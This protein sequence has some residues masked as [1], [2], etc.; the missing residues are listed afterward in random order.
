MA[1][2]KGSASP[3]THPLLP[4]RWPAIVLLGL[5]VYGTIGFWLIERWSF[6]DSLFATVVTISPVAFPAAPLTVG[7]K[8]FTL[9]LILGGAGTVIYALG[10]FAEILTEDRL[11]DYRRQHALQVRIG[12]LRNHSIVCGYGRMGHQLALEFDEAGTPYIV[13]DSN[14]DAVD[15]LR[16]E[17]RLF[18][19][20][21][22]ASE[23]VLRG[24]GIE[25]AR[26]LVSA[27]DSDERAVYITLAA[28]ALNPKL[29]ILVRAGRTE[30]IRRME[31]AGA[32]RVI[33]PYRMAG[34][35]SARLALRPAVVE[36]MEALH[37]GGGT[38]GVE[39]LLLNGGC[40]NI[41]RSLAQAGVL[42]PGCARLLA[43]RRRDGTLQV[44]PTPDLVLAE[45]DLLVALGTREQ[46]ERSAAAVQ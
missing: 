7:G 43:L 10:L 11:G 18:V 15:R 13:V 8:I 30:S 17:R 5:V 34:R 14:P 4:L 38:I 27:I 31:L 39:E 23:D 21:D 24:A 9:T 1:K 41:G 42:A 3:G 26:G 29:H 32:E 28:R 36:T 37:I 45:G 20:G 16:A 22:A 33:N 2:H 25:R 19:E 6:I 40:P 35:Q 44:D 46:L 12:S